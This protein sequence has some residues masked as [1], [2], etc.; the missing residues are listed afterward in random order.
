MV[1]IH[2]GALVS[3]I[4]PGDGLRRRAPWP[5][6]RDRGGVHQ[7]SARRSG[8]AGAFRSSAPPRPTRRVRKL[9]PAG[10][11]RGAEAGCGATW[12]PSAET[13]R[14]SR[15]RA[16]RRAAS[17]CCTSWRLRSARGLFSRAIAESAYMI[18]TPELKRGAALARP[19]RRTA[20]RARW[21]RRAARRPTWRPSAP[22]TRRRSRKRRRVAAHFQPFGAVDGRVLPAPAGRDVFDGGRAGDVCPLLAGFNQRRDPLAAGAG[23]ARARL[24]PRLTRQA[25]R[26]RY[27][28]LAD[29]YLQAPPRAPTRARACWRRRVTPSMAGRPSGWSAAQTAAR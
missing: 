15:W 2:G 8:L 13:P 4:E 19:R 21:L 25:I 12:P 16:S 28:D 5:T 6:A 24:A 1:W 27:G 10:R 9:G 18:S 20:G 26:A 7:L 3:R 11:D 22:W 23:S 17:A 14:R 29:A